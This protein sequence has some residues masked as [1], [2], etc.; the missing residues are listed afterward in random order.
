MDTVDFFLCHL[1]ASGVSLSI[2][3]RL[4]WMMIMGY[5]KTILKRGHHRVHLLSS[6]RHI[7][8]CFVK[9]LKV[10]CSSSLIV[11]VELLQILPA[12]KGFNLHIATERP[13]KVYYLNFEQ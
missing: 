4:R 6:V 9:M 11:V 5:L 3:Y 8:L 2:I 7:V 13:G 12:I 10:K 1:K